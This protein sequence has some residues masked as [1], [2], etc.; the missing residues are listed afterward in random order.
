MSEGQITLLLHNYKTALASLRNGMDFATEA[1]M[2]LQHANMPN[3]EAK[4][5]ELRQG[6]ANLLEKESKLKT[7]EAA[8]KLLQESI[9]NGVEIVFSPI[10]YHGLS[11]RRK[12]GR[13]SFPPI[14]TIC[15][16]KQT[17]IF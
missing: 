6:L 14:W 9:A 3:S 5:L 1:A 13:N 2:D 7:E 4:V 8:L 12:T 15:Q 17:S 16:R 10:N 11:I